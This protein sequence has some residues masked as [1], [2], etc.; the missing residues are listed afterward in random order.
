MGV[1][2]EFAGPGELNDS[3]PAVEPAEVGAVTEG[4]PV[5][6]DAELPVGPVTEELG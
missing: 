3:A 4:M 1:E 2:V 5:L 6:A